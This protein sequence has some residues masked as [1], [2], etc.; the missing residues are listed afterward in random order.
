[1]KRGIILILL[2][3]TL[4]FVFANIDVDVN[5]DKYN[6]G[7]DISISGKINNLEIGKEWYIEPELVCGENSLKAIG[8][9]MQSSLVMGQDIF[10]PGD[11]KIFS[12][13]T[14]DIT[15]DCRIKLT[16]ID[17]DNTIIEEGFSELFIVTKELEGT[18]SINQKTLQLGEEITIIGDIKKFDGTGIEGIVNIILIDSSDKEWIVSQ[19]DM[20]DGKLNFES[21]F[22]ETSIL[23]NPG[24]Y[25]INIMARDIYGNNMLFDNIG[26][27]ELVDKIS[28]FVKANKARFLPAEEIKITGEAK[29]VLQEDVTDADV[30]IKFTQNIYKTKLKDSKF[31]YTFI[32]PPDNP[33]GSQSIVVNIGDSM[34]NNGESSLEINVKAVPTKIDFGLSQETVNPNEKIDIT[35]LL[36]DQADDLIFENLNVNILDNNGKEVYSSIVKTNEEINFEIGQ[37]DESGEWK[38]EASIVDLQGEKTFVVN[39]IEDI[40]VKLI[41]QTLYISNTGNVE[42]DDLLNIQFSGGEYSFKKKT[43][44][45]PNETIVIDLAEEAPTGNYDI[46]ITSAAITGGAISFDNVKVVGKKMKSFNFFYTILIMFA[47]ACFVY[48]LA[49][50]KKMITGVKLRQDKIFKKAKQDK[51]K[52]IKIKEEKQRKKPINFKNRETS[53]KDFRKRM[54]KEIKATENKQKQSQDISSPQKPEGGGLFNMFDR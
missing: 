37:F 32:I 30:T 48:L 24:V 7:E 50:K 26:S 38:V 21:N 46:S 4:P 23:N 19:S 49:F 3:L 5:K 6:L 29:T 16:I 35:P 13:K 36:Y 34:G 43:S 17:E 54:L 53:V 20:I 31:E 25:R 45:R 51:E 8:S 47:L 12:I 18:F 2:V 11:L 1:M 15:G 22:E 52:F 33:S 42:Y 10:I 44:I 28:V 40:E 41:N 39:E 27:F 9:M 14:R